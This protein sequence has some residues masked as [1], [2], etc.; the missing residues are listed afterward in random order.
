MPDASLSRLV[1]DL[2]SPDPVV[3]DESAYA[4]LSALVRTGALT[5]GDRASL[6][7]AMLERLRHDRIE[8]RAFAPLVLAALVRAGDGEQ[9]WV[10][11]VTTWYVGERDQRG[12]DP[13]LGWLHAVAH[14]ADFF[15]ACGAA[16]LGRPADLLDALARRL[17]A[18][19]PCVWR[20]QED[21]RVAH[22]L[23]LVLARSDL[24]EVTS[25]A[26]LEH[27]RRL[28]AAGSPG[29][30]PP[31][32]TNTMHTLRSLHLALG[33]QPLDSGI[34]VTVPHADLVR[35]EIAA[36]LHEVTPWAWRP[37]RGRA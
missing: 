2:A 3:R 5:P 35:V 6:A 25:V 22:A 9:A 15:G 13:L 23:A 10:P 32:A 14:G 31:E 37:R 27:V 17:V 24:D 11:A 21:D 28:F 29:S 30:V 19:T 1:H 33:E 12:H 36:L 8:A 18:P 16:G 34:P 7:T 4:A 26:W 20:D